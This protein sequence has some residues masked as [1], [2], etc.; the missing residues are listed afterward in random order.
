MLRLINGLIDLSGRHGAHQ[1]ER[2]LKLQEEDPV[3]QKTEWGPCKSGGVSFKTRS[4]TQPSQHRLEFKPSMIAKVFP[5]IFLSHALFFLIAQLL[6]PH[7]D[8]LSL[9]FT[10]VFSLPFVGGGVYLWLKFTRP[11]IFDRALRSYWKGHKDPERCSERARFDEIHAVQLIS[12]RVHQGSSH[13][14]RG[15][16]RHGSSYKSYELNLVLRDGRRMNVIDHGSLSVIREDAE[17]VAA[18]LDKPLW[19]VV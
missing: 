11:I 19:D 15:Y 16:R 5:I 12:E 18:L 8:L 6:T 9:I 4:L 13:G 14:A 7:L 3:A 17:R 2:V 10:I 1:D